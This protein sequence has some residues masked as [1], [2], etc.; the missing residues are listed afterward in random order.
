MKHK[1]IYGIAIILGI[2]GS[3]VTMALHPMGHDIL[4]N[5]EDIFRRF[6]MLAV[7]IHA[8]AICSLPLLF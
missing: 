3:I 8:L 4:D 5:A 6:E 7:A 1:Q 2:L